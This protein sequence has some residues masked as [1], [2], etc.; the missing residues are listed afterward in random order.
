[1]ILLRAHRTGDLSQVAQTWTIRVSVCDG[2]CPPRVGHLIAK[3]QRSGSLQFLSKQIDFGALRPVSLTEAAVRF[4][5][6]SVAELALKDDVP[7][8][9]VTSAI[10]FRASMPWKSYSHGCL[11]LASQYALRL[12]SGGFKIT[13]TRTA[14]GFS[15]WLSANQVIV[16]NMEV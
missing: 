15:Y 7:S 12:P 14:E 5:Q 9:R 10:P 13:V 4:R 1:M 16:G 8:S 3:F 2:S 11:P 6:F